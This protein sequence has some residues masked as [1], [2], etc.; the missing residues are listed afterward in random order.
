[1]LAKYDED[2]NQKLE[3]AEFAALITQLR[4]F[5]AK[6]KPPQPKKKG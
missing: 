3:F 5:Q 1:M 2:Q 4:D 6:R